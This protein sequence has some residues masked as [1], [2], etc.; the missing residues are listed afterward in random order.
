MSS[1]PSRR[2]MFRAVLVV[3]LVNAIT[4]DRLNVRLD[5]DTLRFSSS[6][7]RLLSGKALAQLKSGN[8]VGF[9]WQVAIS[10]DGF[11]TTASRTPGRFVVSYDLWEEKFSVV[12]A[13]NSQR[14]ATHLTGKAAEAWCFESMSI[15]AAGLATDRPLWV[16]LDLRVEDGRQ[17]AAVVGEGGINLTRL[18][19][20]FSRPAG[21]QQATWIFTAGP[22]RL[23]DLRRA[24]PGLRGG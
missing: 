11:A 4:S 15:S 2:D 19:E 9:V 21:A 5:G 8:T 17:P 18:I 24:D 12:R 7:V 22:L 3:P 23:T 1:E 14:S 16:R 20:I 10:H 13:G 6:Q